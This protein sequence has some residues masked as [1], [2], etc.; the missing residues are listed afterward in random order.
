MIS[1]PF[2]DEIVQM[3]RV[4]SGEPPV[5]GDVLLNGKKQYGVYGDGIVYISDGTI[6]KMPLAGFAAES[7]RILRFPEPYG[8]GFRLMDAFGNVWVPEFSEEDRDFLRKIGYQVHDAQTTVSKIKS[9][10][11]E[12]QHPLYAISCKTGV[13]VEDDVRKLAICLQKVM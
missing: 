1:G 4:S 10:L 6:Q 2:T 13:M 9:A 7:V 8:D 12:E 5:Y 11:G 3:L